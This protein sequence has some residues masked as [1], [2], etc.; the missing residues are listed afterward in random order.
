M[1]CVECMDVGYNSRISQV[2]ECIIDN[3]SA[4]A[5]GVENVE[6]GVF[7][8]RVTEVR[9]GEGTSMERSCVDRLILASSPLVDDPVISQEVMDVLSRFWL[10]LLIDEDKGVMRW[11][12]KVEFHPFSSWVVIVVEHFCLCCDVDGE[13]LEKGRGRANFFFAIFDVRTYHVQEYRDECEVGDLVEDIIGSG[14]EGQVW[15]VLGIEV[16][17][18]YEVVCPSSHSII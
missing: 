1:L 10:R 15:I 18:A 3:D 4:R 17:A 6:V 9:G 16:N 11:I 14:E 2:V 7:D 13:T 12:G 8:T 5:A